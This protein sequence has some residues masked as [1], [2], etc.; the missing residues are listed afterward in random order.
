MP[1]SRVKTPPVLVSP[2]GFGMMYTSPASFFCDEQ[3]LMETNKS[4]AKNAAAG[5]LKILLVILFNYFYE[6]SSFISTLQEQ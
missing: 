2:E 6:I 5:I 1:F 4:A 3:E